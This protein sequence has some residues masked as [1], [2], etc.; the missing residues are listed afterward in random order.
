MTVRFPEQYKDRIYRVN[1]TMVALPVKSGFGIFATVIQKEP[2]GEVKDVT[3][4][5]ISEEV[6]PTLELAH[7]AID[8]NAFHIKKNLLSFH[9]YY[10]E[11]FADH[12]ISM[13]LLRKMDSGNTET[14]FY[15]I[16]EMAEN[17]NDDRANDTWVYRTVSVETWDD[18]DEATEAFYSGN[19]TRVDDVK[20]TPMMLGLP[21]IQILMNDKGLYDV[22]RPWLMLMSGV[23]HEASAELNYH[24]YVKPDLKT[25]EEAEQ[26][27]ERYWTQF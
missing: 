25:K 11:E 1:N 19:W 12:A 8:T 23:T 17:H 14:D 4:L 24:E 15:A 9:F 16:V 26:A 2:S 21:P 10:E 13:P 6:Y 18:K 3:Y 7:D 5:W 27:L 20:F 22:A